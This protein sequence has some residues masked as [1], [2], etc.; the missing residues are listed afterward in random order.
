MHTNT[1]ITFVI[2]CILTAALQASSQSQ[3]RVYASL[4]I[5]FSRGIQW[6]EGSNDGPFVIGVLDYGPLADELRALLSNMRIDGRKTEIRELRGADEANGLNVLFI[7]AFKARMLQSFTQRT[8]SPETLVV[9]NKPGLAQLGSDI[10]LVLVNGKLRYEIN[11]RAIE[12]RGM[13][14]AAGIKGMGI[15]VG[16]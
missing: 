8:S 14:I 16:D 5:N 4:L 10:N 13:R 3:E 1:R 12:D 9:T 15:V 6:P 11:C 2:V 7:P